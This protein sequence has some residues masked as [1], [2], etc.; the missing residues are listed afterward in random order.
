MSDSP[1]PGL[2]R[3]DHADRAA[4]WAALRDRIGRLLSDGIARDGR[5]SLILSG[6]RTPIPLFEAL[7]TLDIGWDKVD[8]SLAD[9][10]W[11]PETDPDS[12]AAL[13]RRHLLADK[14]KGA[15]L[16][17]LFDEGGSAAARADA[18]GK[19]IAVMKRPFDCVILGMGDDGHTASL[20]PDAPELAAGLT[21]PGPCLAMT[22]ASVPQARIT[23]PL[24]ALL[25]TA[26]ILLVLAGAGKAAVLDRAFEPGPVEEM[27]VRAVLRQTQAPVAVHWAP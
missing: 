6:G 16:I 11:V 15:R 14:A 21:Q 20:F 22:P 27:P 23:L 25:D 17:P 18:A 7:S 19:R 5:G 12:N 13:I 9:E 1:Q 26:E 8:I 2:S 3:T 24:P 10:R 4:M